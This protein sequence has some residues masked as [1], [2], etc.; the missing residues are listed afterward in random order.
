MYIYI[1]IYIH[2]PKILI[3][4]YC[5]LAQ[6]RTK[7]IEECERRL[8]QAR[9]DKRYWYWYLHIVLWASMAHALL[10]FGQPRAR[11]TNTLVTHT[12]TYTH[13]HTGVGPLARTGIGYPP[14]L[15]GDGRRRRRRHSDWHR[16]T[17]D[18]S[19][20]DWLWLRSAIGGRLYSNNIL[21]S[22]FGEEY[23]N[24]GAIKT[25]RNIIE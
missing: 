3:F 23:I 4:T 24:I 13:T 16:L 17:P 11:V 21:I 6:A 18:H 8:A 2:A 5:T 15:D 25:M 14:L 19:D 7:D 22:E 1:Y 9:T 20:T 12:H 10:R